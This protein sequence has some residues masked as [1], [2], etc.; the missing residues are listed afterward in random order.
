[1]SVL[2]WRTHYHLYFVCV[3]VT[4]APL[5]AILI[6]TPLTHSSWLPL[7]YVSVNGSDSVRVWV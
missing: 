2:V 4:A 7:V 1:M 5:V 3:H 6:S